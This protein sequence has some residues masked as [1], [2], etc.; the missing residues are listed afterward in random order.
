ME[1]R[2]PFYRQR[3]GRQ[4]QVSHID[5]TP[6]EERAEVNQDIG[7]RDILVKKGRSANWR[8]IAR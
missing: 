3:W 8:F 6:G 5:I 7:N 4:I 2:S 1:Q